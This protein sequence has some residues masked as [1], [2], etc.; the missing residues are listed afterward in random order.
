MLFVDGENFTI[1]AQS[2]A[3]ENNFSLVEGPHYRKDT[4]VWLP[5]RSPTSATVMTSSALQRVGVR[6]SYY[7][8]ISG[9]EPLLTAVRE[10]LWSLGF[11]PHVFKKD[12]QSKK[13]KGVDITLTKD[14]LS[15]AFLG[16]YDDA[17]LVAGDADYVPLVEE[18]KRLGKV[19]HVLFFKSHGLS[20]ELRR[21][22]DAFEDISDL[23]RASWE[24][25]R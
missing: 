22:A 4:F 10:S 3:V 5:G 18:I 14:M 7:T 15:H 13:T 19:V 24:Q 1:R 8:S 11:D 25:R 20:P 12:S 9:D 16:N 21:S 17:G 6:A 23:F 2:F